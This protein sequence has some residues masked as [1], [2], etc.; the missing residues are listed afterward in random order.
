M[1]EEDSPKK[2]LTRRR[3]LKTGVVGGAFLLA[4]SMVAIFRTRGYDLSPERE[5]KLVALSAWQ[6]V[7]VEQAARRI[8]APDLPEDKSIPTSDET[9][10]AGFVDRY[11][12]RMPDAMRRDLTRLFA[13]V[14][15]L[16]PLRLKLS[17][18]FTRLAPEEQDRVLASLETSEE[19]LL[20]GG[21]E[22]LKSL[23]FMGYYR[24]P[25]TWKV[26]G[27]AGPWVG[28]PDKGWW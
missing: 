24:D 16:A 15:H 5:A 11:V 7:F 4:G 23:V 13:Y 22:G 1:M 27:Y 25:R 21:F 10:V 9:D 12:S 14:E 17:S 6:A 8:T 2:P 28:R 18:R 3:F 20:R 19:T 26:L